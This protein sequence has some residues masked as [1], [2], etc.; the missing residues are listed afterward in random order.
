MSDQNEPTPQDEYVNVEGPGKGSSIS[1]YVIK[2]VIA[3]IAGAGLFYGG[4]ALKG[5][6]QEPQAPSALTEKLTV[7]EQMKAQKTFQAGGDQGF[8]VYEYPQQN[9]EDS[10]YNI[11]VKM[12]Q[13]MV[14][15]NEEGL[16]SLEA[17]VRV[18]QF[19][20]DITDEVLG[21]AV[22]TYGKTYEMKKVPAKQ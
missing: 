15:I 4:Y 18:T 17:K 8:T 3:A 1:N 10:K 5:E 20:E 9:Q 19:G 7:E 2:P 14:N 11:T 16:G 21:N 13:N 12:G 6:L 22:G